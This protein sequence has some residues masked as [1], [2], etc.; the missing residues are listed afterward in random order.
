MRKDDCIFCKIANGG[1]PSTTVYEDEDF[2]AI[3]DLSP[4]SRGHTL[5]IPKEHSDDLCRLDT[6][7]AQKVLPVAAR[8]G[9]AMKEA[10]HCDGFNL[11]QNN[12]EAAGQTVQHFHMHIIPRYAGSGAKIAAWE[13]GESDEEERESIGAAIRQAL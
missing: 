1:I 4:A 2:R 10:L 5:V 9:A 7:T 12:G 6:K 3:L 11:V 8:I 13:P